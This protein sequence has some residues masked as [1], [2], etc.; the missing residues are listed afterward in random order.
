MGDLREPYWDVLL[1]QEQRD[2]LTALLMD[3]EEDWATDLLGQL[4]EKPHG[5]YLD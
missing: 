3:K 2:E 4:P 5:H 1:T